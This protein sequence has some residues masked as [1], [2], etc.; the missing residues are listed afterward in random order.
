[1]SDDLMRLADDGNPLEPPAPDPVRVAI[2]DPANDPVE[3]VRRVV[4]T[5]AGQRNRSA[6]TT[7]GVPLWKPVMEV[8]QLG[9]GSARRVCERYGYDPELR[10]RPLTWRK[11]GDR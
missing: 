6:S 4:R 5:F 7:A 3:L 2:P 11:Y 9:Q 1:M 8:L 10:V